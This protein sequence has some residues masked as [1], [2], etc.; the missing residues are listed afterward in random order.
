MRGTPVNVARQTVGVHGTY[1]DDDN[2][3]DA[4]N[5]GKSIV[6]LDDIKGRDYQ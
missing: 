1:D 3:E 2:D 6:I 4:D 5:K